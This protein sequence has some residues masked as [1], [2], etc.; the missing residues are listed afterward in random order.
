MAAGVLLGG[1]GGGPATQEGV[2]LRVGIGVSGA[3][4]R[5]G[6]LDDASE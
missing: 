3:L 5:A 1:L 6:C 2:S 4:R